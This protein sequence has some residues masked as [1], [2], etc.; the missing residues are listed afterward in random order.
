LQLF[1]I[2]PGIAFTDALAAGLLEESGG[3][4]A[5]LATQTIL[6]PTRRACRNLRDT[7]LRLSNGKPL[8]LPRIQPLG[9]VD[10]DELA[11]EMA[12]GEN[13]DSILA[14]PPALAPLRRSILLARLVMKLPEYSDAPHLAFGLAESLGGLMDRV[15]TENLSLRDLAKL[16]PEDYAAHWQITVGFLEILSHRWPEILAA[17]GAIDAADRRNRLLHMLAAHWRAHPPAEPVTAAGVTGTT[18]AAAKLLQ[19]I[20][21]M[22]RGR[23]V[24]PGLDKRMDDASWDALEDSHPQCA[25]KRILTGIGAE[26]NRVQDW[27]Y[28]PPLPLELEPLPVQQAQ[29]RARV[30]LSSELMRP[31]ATAESWTGLSAGIDEDRKDT[32]RRTLLRVQR[33]DCDTSEEEAHVIALLLRETLEV[34]ARRAALITPDRK[35]ARRVATACQRWGIDV[36][37]S[38]GSGLLATPPG[39]WLNLC[40]QCC[41]DEIRPLTLAALVKHRLFALHGQSAALETGLLR[42]AA[43]ERG[44]KGLYKRLAE[45]KDAAP[46]LKETLQ[47]IE[48]GLAPLIALCD[49]GKHDFAALTDAHIAAAENLSAGP[50]ALW[51]DDAGETAAVFLANLREEAKLIPP[52]TA[53]DYIAIFTQLAASVTV[54]SPYGLHPRLTIL[55]QIEARLAQPDLVIMGGMN[56]GGWPAQAEADPWMSR[57]MRET[58]G[59]PSPEVNI[60]L[61]AHDFA[62]GFCAADVVLTR[63]RRV[64]GTPTVPSRWLQRLDTLLTA[65]GFE[66]KDLQKGGMLH[67]ARMLDRPGEPPKPVARPEPRPPADKRPDSLY[68]TAI[69]KW[70]RDPYSIY[71]R[72]ILKLRKEEEIE[73]DADAALRGT[74]IHKALERFIA[75]HPDGLPPDALARL[76]ETGR[77][78]FEK[79]SLDEGR[80]AFWWPRFERLAAW[81]IG[82]ETEWRE[83]ARP[84]LLETNGTLPLKNFTL[85]ANAD[86]I[87]LLNDGS[88]AI[89][90]YKTGSSP[91]KGDIESGYSPQLPLEAA[92]LIGGGFEK[93]G[94]RVPGYLGF[95]KLTGAQVAGE[96]KKVNTA[97]L[98]GLAEKAREG[99][100]A[101]VEKFADETTPY[102]SLP[103]PDKAPPKAHQDYAHLAR[104]QEWAALGEN[105]SE[106]A[107]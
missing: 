43:P 36:D 33:Y 67:H 69:E 19:T 52:V 103:R 70:M 29:R 107:A 11:L 86:R 1:T 24:F 88:A 62:Q 37:D 95:W 81:F 60:G 74:L 66:P 34:K 96:E 12:Q 16:V 77:E 80:K 63:S 68:V 51:Q 27:P 57:P 84:L 9:D 102:L 64:D 21:E 93:A 7:F 50:E 20:A 17:E 89:I 2:D 83:N 32:L 101:L 97:D 90:D 22:A 10:G 56:E 78:E 75:A 5:R 13:A 3:D 73:E 48:A 35:L 47:K 65:L 49:G 31:A 98:T 18:P 28:L 44:F 38:A 26:R 45:K 92:I 41:L 58:F 25:M 71:A 82:H 72:Y 85:K 4:P 53:A 61:S 79:V 91:G 14:L 100:E 23:V 54:R 40:A 104:V 76:I 42:G 87:D 94:K 39:A 46:A 59:L 30:W 8:L 15:Y 99:L 106:D 105:D 6:L 55:G